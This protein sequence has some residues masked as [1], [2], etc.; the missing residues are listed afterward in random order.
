[1]T[2][3]KTNPP[4]RAERLA[5]ASRGDLIAWRARRNTSATIRNL[6]ALTP[7]CNKRVGYNQDPYREDAVVRARRESKTETAG[8]IET[9]CTVAWTGCW[10]TNNIQV[11]FLAD[12][13]ERN[14]HAC[15]QLRSLRSGDQD[16]LTAGFRRFRRPA[17]RQRQVM[18]RVS[19]CAA[20]ARVVSSL[21]WR[22]WY[23]A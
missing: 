11:S 3:H 18:R 12:L 1:M 21:V 13:V 22:A 19:S 15:R 9:A 14:L 5:Y 23:R 16:L 20:R 10:S 17:V 7:D 4:A 6:A 8:F 2:Q